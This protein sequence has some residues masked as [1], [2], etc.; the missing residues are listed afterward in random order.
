MGACTGKSSK[1]GLTHSRE[2][3]LRDLRDDYRY[4]PLNAQDSSFFGSSVAS[5]EKLDIIQFAAPIFVA[6]EGETFHV[7]LMRLGALQGRVS[8][9][10]RTEQSAGSRYVHTEGQVI[11]EDGCFEQLIEIPILESP[12][13]SATLEFKVVLDEPM[14]CQLGKYLKVCRVKV[15]DQDTF[16][17][18][19][20]SEEIKADSIEDISEASLF[21][22]Y[23]KL[24]TK[25]PGNSWRLAVTLL[26]DQLKNAYV[27][28]TLVSSVYMVNVVFGHGTS[29]TSQELLIPDDPAKTAQ[30]I[31]LMYVSF[32]LLLHLWKVVKIKM[33]LNGRC[34]LFLQ[35]SMMRNY[36]DTS[37]SEVTQAE[38]VRFITQDSAKLARSISDVSSLWETL[39]KLVMLNYFAVSNNPDMTWAV[40]TMPVAMI[41]WSLMREGG[42]VVAKPDGTDV[43]EKQLEDFVGIVSE[44]Y[45]LIACYFQRPAMND[46]FA[47]RAAKLQE[48][49]IPESSYD[50]TSEFFFQWLAPLFVGCYMAFYSPLVLSGELALGTF[51]ATISVFKEVSSNFVDGYGGLKKVRK[52]FDPLVQI[53]IFLNRSTDVAMLKMSV[54]NRVAETELC[55]RKLMKNPGDSRFPTDQIPIRLEKLSLM[56]PGTE[57]F[58]FRDLQQSVQQGHL[59]ELIGN[60]GSGKTKLIKLLAGEV[61]ASSGKVLTPSHLRCLLVT[62]QVFLMDTTPLQNLFFGDPSS[63]VEQSERHRMLWILQKL[64][65]DRT[66]QLAEEEISMLQSSGE[67]EEESLEGFCCVGPRRRAEMDPMEMWMPK[68]GTQRAADVYKRFKGWRSSLS[69][70]ER[71]KLHLARA[72]IMNPEILILEKPLMNLDDKESETVMAVLR[73]FVSNRGVALDLETLEYRRPRTCFYSAERRTMNTKTDVVWE[74]KEGGQLVTSAPDAHPDSPMANSQSDAKS[75]KRKGR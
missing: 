1:H 5:K 50:L 31:G 69:F 43:F 66:R 63:V 68:D 32:P 17:T 15:I 55:R 9:S 25:V 22:E 48:T 26:F 21:I 53:S 33:D 40:I 57:N 19:K 70:Q 42:W 52:A 58:L 47:A 34:K 18:S 4:S 30:V 60:A 23:M 8:C 24:M 59:V 56:L 71:A 6:E 49:E 45:P 61:A 29:K 12:T 13:W 62:H 75:P 39:G 14:G 36:S 10:F 73:E 64:S 3:R 20:Y 46:R 72:L 2:V 54:D 41:F 35:S 27:W 65:M 28:F 44:N 11:F 51:L 74:F 38:V 7:H 16:P 67:I 37:R